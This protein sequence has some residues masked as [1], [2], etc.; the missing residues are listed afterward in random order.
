MSQLNR[1]CILNKTLGEADVSEV[2]S[3][4][5]AE[6]T[7]MTQD[8]KKVNAKCILLA[9]GKLGKFFYNNS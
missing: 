7:L 1:T 5:F 3:K 4:S 6:N 8:S 2:L 9:T